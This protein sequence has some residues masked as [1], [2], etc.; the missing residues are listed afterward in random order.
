MSSQ[1]RRVAVQKH[2]NQ[3]HDGETLPSIARRRQTG[4]GAARESGLS[5]SRRNA[6]VRSKGDDVHSKN[7]HEPVAIQPIWEEWTGSKEVPKQ[8]GE[9]C[10]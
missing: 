10:T 2:I 4:R 5:R 1:A 8:V 6:L 3:F 7:G 9:G